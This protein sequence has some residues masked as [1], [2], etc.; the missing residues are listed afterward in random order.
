MVGVMKERRGWERVRDEKEKSGSNVEKETR[1][2]FFERW[3]LLNLESVDT[4]LHQ[5][6]IKSNLN[7]IQKL[8]T[9]IASSLEPTPSL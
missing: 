4:F 1:E 9:S 7:S 2:S 5:N 8:V 3:S 6:R